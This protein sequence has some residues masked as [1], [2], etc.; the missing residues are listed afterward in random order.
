MGQTSGASF[1]HHDKL[2]SPRG[3]G[4]WDRDRELTP[5]FLSTL[6]GCSGDDE[7][8]DD[9]DD[10]DDEKEEEERRGGRTAWL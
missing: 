8:E 2:P 1:G 5:A 7:D 4:I 3:C 9:D 6:A 10:D